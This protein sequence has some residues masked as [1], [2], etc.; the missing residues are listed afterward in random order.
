MS[1]VLRRLVNMHVCCVIRLYGMMDFGVFFG[2]LKPSY[3]KF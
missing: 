1:Y 3:N 2:P